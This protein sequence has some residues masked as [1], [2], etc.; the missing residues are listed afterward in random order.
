MRSTA[1][2]PARLT[3]KLA[4]TLLL[5]AGVVACEVDELASTET[6]VCTSADQQAQDHPQAAAFQDLIDADLAFTTG[7]QVAVIDARG[8]PWTGTAGYA[9]I[10]ADA[11]YRSCTRSPVASITKLFT[12]ALVLQARERGLLDLE[13]RL[14]DRLPAALLDDLANADEATL[15]QLLAHTSGIP[16]YLTLRQAL[17]ALNNPFLTETQ[18]QKLDYARGLAATH[19]VGSDFAYSN[20]NYTLLGLVLERVY[21][22]DLHVLVDRELAQPFGLIGLAMGRESDPIPDDVARPYLALT[23]GKFQNVISSAVADAATADGGLLASVGEL[24]VLAEAL[25]GGRLVSAASLAE[26]QAD[27]T[28]LTPEQSDFDYWPEE[29]YGLGITRYNTPIGVAYG[30]TGSTS[31]YNSTLLYFSASGVYFSIVRNGVDLQRVDESL[32]Q[33]RRTME[34]FLTLLQ[35]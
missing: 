29:A 9:D 19:A 25:F 13:D 3:A 15:R 10:G 2:S 16:D 18:E 34:A 5:A 32:A 26:M 20:T 31:A 8:R 22:E 27:P 11:A 35:E 12:A 33:N 14:A 1:I 23:G 28:I 30:H 21:G 17:D 6:Y 4:L 7:V 24:G